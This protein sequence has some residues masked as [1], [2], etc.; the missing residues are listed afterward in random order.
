MWIATNKGWLSIVRHRNKEN[1]L[2]VRA[3][4]KNHIES[5]FEDAEV[6]E[7]ANADYPYRADIH[8]YTV[9]TVI[10]D[11][12]MG[13]NYDNF[14]ASV[15]DYHYHHALVGVWDEMYRYGKQ[16]RPK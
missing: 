14:K 6:Y 12:L 11:L 8:L 3:R 5:I 13:I 4:N 2:L 10:G 15:D 9:G 7:D 16:Y 1:T